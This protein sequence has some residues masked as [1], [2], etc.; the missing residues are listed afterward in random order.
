MDS[1]AASGESDLLDEVLDRIGDS[2]P[3]LAAFARSYLHRLPPDTAPGPD[4]AYQ[5]VV[6]LFEFIEQRGESISVRVFNPT[7]ETHGY[8][9]EGTVLEVHVDDSPFLVDSIT[10]ELQAHGLEV[11]RVLHPVIGTVRDESGLLTDVVRARDTDSR[12]SIQHYVLDRRLDPIDHD[13]LEGRIEA[14]LSD[15]TL[16]VRDFAAMVA[17]AERMTDLASEGG[18]PYPSAEVDEAAEFL[19]WLSQDNFVFLGYR[20]YRIAET[21]R[22]KA[23]EVIPESGLGILSDPSSSRVAQPIPLDELSPELRARWEHGDLLTISKTNRLATVHRR[24]RM[25]YVSVRL[26]NPDAETR[27]ETRLLGLFTAK[28]YMESVTRIP[29]L[30]EKLADIVSGEDMVEGS[31]DHKAV[32]E[33]IESYPKDELFSL[34]TRDLRRVVLGLLAMEGR[35][36]VRL[37]VRRGLLDRSVR[38]LVA[39]PRDRYSA[40]LTQR[41]RELFLERYG[42]ISSDHHLS[43]GETDLARLHFVVWV[44]EGHTPKIAFEDMEAEVMDLTRSWSQRVGDV[45]RE[46][47]G[48][49]RAQEVVAR[50]SPRLPSYYK[51]WTQLAVA[52]GDIERLDELME[53]RGELLVGIQN[54]LEDAEPL[55][56]VALYRAGGKEPLSDLIPA[57]EDMGLEVVEEVPTRLSAPDDLFIH[58][59]G[60]VGPGGNLVDVEEAGDR[61]AAALTAVWEGKAESDSLNRLI[62]VSG[63]DHQQ[64]AIIRAYHVYWRRV[65]PL[66]TVEYVHNALATHADITADLVRLFELTFDP[67][68]DGVGHEELYQD[69]AARLDAIPSLDEDRILRGFLRL[70]EAT[71]RTNAYK[72][73]RDSLAFKFR[74][75][76]V[77]DLPPPRPHVEVFVIADEVEGVHLRAGPLARGGIRWS[78]RREDYRT[79][80]LDLMKAQVTKNAFI[81]PTGAKGGFVLRRRPTDPAELEAAV[82]AAYEIFIRGLLDLTDNLVD[83]NVVHPDGVRVHDEPD[84]YLV[85]A[86]DRGTARFSDVANRI[87]DDY[88][89]WLGDAFAS[90]GVTGYDHKALGITALG[91]WKSLEAHFIPDGIDPR[92]ETFTVVGIGDMSGDVFGNGMLCSETIMLVAA[93]DHRHLFLDPQPDPAVSYRERQRLASLPRSSWADYDRDLLSEGGGIYSLSAKQIVLSPQA[94]AALGTEIERGTP[95]EVIRTILK[96]PVDVIWNGGIGTFVKESAETDEE[97]GDRTND[98]VRVV[99]S[100]VR[101]RIVVEGG[102]LGF[103]QRGRIEYALAG[104]RINADFIDNSGGVDC[105]DREVNLKILLRMAEQRGEISPTESRELLAAEAPD[106]VD[107]IAVDSL[108]QALM[109]TV[110]HALSGEQLYAYEHLMASLEKAGRLDRGLDHLPSTQEMADRVRSGGAMTRPELAILSAHAKRALTDA[111]LASDLPDSTTMIRDL[112]A[113]FPEEVAKRFGHLMWDHPLRRELIATIVASDVVN[114]LGPAFAARLMART[115][116]D[117]ASVVSA[118]HAARDLVGGSERRR[119]IA[120]LVGSLEFQ[121]WSELIGAEDRLVATLTRW[122]LRHHTATRPEERW[123]EEFSQFQAEAVRWGSPAWRDARQTQT[124]DLQAKGVTKPAAERAVMAP[125]LVHAPDILELTDTT[126]RARLEV[127]SLFVRVGEELGLDRLHVVVTGLKPTDRWQRWTQEILEDDLLDLRRLV[128]ERILVDAEGATT[129]EALASFLAERTAPVA[130]VRELAHSLDDGGNDPTPVLVIIRQIQDL[131]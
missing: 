29:I 15:V 67:A 69:I 40:E 71:V 11:V 24:A 97:V 120:D 106:I 10:A 35:S 4:H 93:F 80:V 36:Q 82:R 85:V 54:D 90:G 117:A 127:G 13:P 56:R 78:Q 95:A 3:L 33:L 65:R 105:S 38:I 63:L 86:A 70:I 77:P 108:G 101:A 43:L 53:S 61:V 48:F 118:Y 102:N 22:G 44:P 74:C 7:E 31:H 116:A 32:V 64:V 109:L 98:E 23:V 96:A 92:R 73:D 89:F 27:G 81:V 58:D 99:A 41:L 130:R 12:E 76:D 111:V 26:V 129:D 57:L 91:A 18:G 42:G 123:A 112:T 126:G 124:Q 45:L 84:S 113:Y 119:T 62:L 49:A 55:T 83:G 28:A 128:V 9:S 107:S 30:R 115:G 20:E 68:S 47:H 104:G 46:R 94:R 122:Y 66:F 6:G 19:R 21:P 51:T 100:D 5:E 25:D 79:E 103:T 39:M 34:P 50:W 2:S 121:V 16:A 52:A 37:F 75:V 60:V 110:E 17:A 59:F 8:E 125:D 14:I 88:G 114:H 72:P 1:G 131:V 87:A